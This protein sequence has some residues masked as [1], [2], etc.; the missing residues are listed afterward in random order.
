MLKTSQILLRKSNCG[1]GVWVPKSLSCFSSLEHGF[2]AYGVCHSLCDM[3]WKYSSWEYFDYLDSTKKPYTG[4][5]SP[6]SNTFYN[7]IFK[8]WD[9]RE[10]A[11]LVFPF[12]GT[13]SMQKPPRAVPMQSKRTSGNNWLNEGNT[14]SPEAAAILRDHLYNYVPFWDYGIC[15]SLLGV[16]ER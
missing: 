4:I 10:G 16:A 5:T 12:Y 1:L 11:I 14:L 7:L 8:V 3:L 13:D 9:V 6:G 15:N 2:Y